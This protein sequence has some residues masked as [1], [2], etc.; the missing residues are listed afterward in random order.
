MGSCR[1]GILIEK[2]VR[3]RKLDRRFYRR[4]HDW[5]G[6]KGHEL[7]R[8]AHQK[9][10]WFRVSQDHASFCWISATTLS[11]RGRCQLRNAPETTISRA[12]TTET[13]YWT[14]SR[15]PGTHWAEFTPSSFSKLFHL[16]TEEK[17]HARVSADTRTRG[18]YFDDLTLGGFCSLAIIPSCR[19]QTTDL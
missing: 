13:T 5:Q 6:W 17:F 8:S 14:S 18:I 15:N 1:E 7:Q 2:T 11:D 19:C 12:T 16:S 10:G 4:C 3:H 9:I